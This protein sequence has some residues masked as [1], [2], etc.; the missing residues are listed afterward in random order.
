MIPQVFA[1][2]LED[3]RAWK[4]IVED[5]FDAQCLGMTELPTETHFVERLIIDKWWV[6]RT[7]FPPKLT[8]DDVNTWRALKR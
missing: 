8:L 2:K 1:D 4:E 5:F 6:D 7:T 3:W